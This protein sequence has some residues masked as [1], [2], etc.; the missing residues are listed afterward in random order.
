[1]RNRRVAF[2]PT[3]I[4]FAG[5][6]TVRFA[7]GPISGV[8]AAGQDVARTQ[9]DEAVIIKVLANDGDPDESRLEI[10]KI[11]QAGKG[12]VVVNKDGTVTYKPKADFCG[13]DE[14]SYT[15]VNGKGQS[16]TTSVQVT[17]TGVNDIPEI[18]SKPTLT[19]STGQE[20][21]YDVNG[22]DP[23][24]GDRLSYS[25]VDG[26][27]G[28]SIDATTGEIRWTPSEDQVGRQSVKVRVADSSG[29]YDEQ[30]FPVS[31]EHAGPAGKVILHVE[32]DLRPVDVINL[33]GAGSAGL[34]SQSNDERWQ[35][36]AGGYVCYEFSDALIPSGA[37]IRSVIVYVEHHEDRGFP[38]GKLIW[39]IGA[40]WPS[41][42][43]EWVS[44]KAPLRETAR[45][46]GLDSWDVTSFANTIAKV[47]A[48]E[49]RME[50]H[51]TASPK[52]VFVD[53]AYVVVSW[54]RQ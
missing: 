32:R 43:V 14:F 3:L 31:V 51:S 11:G 33:L 45:W 15:V 28:I 17:V 53:H 24:P 47:N 39:R 38:V 42:G 8:L 22:A 20:Y 37:K 48:L 35:T 54:E 36:H 10:T 50:N 5:L 21:F 41:N 1:L 2:L 26:P 19:G 40:G 30:S 12:T 9:E 6:L 16:A 49:L 7:V 23:D 27:E 4:I 46:E 25:V 18:V 29:G 44:V 52:R 34:V 13:S